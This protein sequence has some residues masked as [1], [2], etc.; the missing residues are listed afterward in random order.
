[1][2]YTGKNKTK[3]G[4]KQPKLRIKKDDVVYVKSG[5]DRGAEG[6]VLSVDVTRQRATIEGVNIMKRHRKQG[7]SG[8]G[9]ITDIPAPVHV[10]NLVVVCPHC[11]AHTRPTKKMVERTREGKTRRFHVRQCRKCGEQLDQV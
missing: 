10:S 4:D 5:K 6:K 9:G 11:K 7:E 1:M 3:A 2:A 8:G